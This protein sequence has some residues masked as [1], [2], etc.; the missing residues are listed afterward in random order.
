MFVAW[1]RRVANRRM[2]NVATDAGEP[3]IA[4]R[5]KER[6]LADALKEV[7]YSKSFAAARYLPPEFHI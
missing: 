4:S 5:R 2:G 3:E 6:S 1:P 7:G